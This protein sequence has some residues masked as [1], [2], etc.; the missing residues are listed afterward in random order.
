MSPPLWEPYHGRADWV[1]REEIL[2]GTRNSVD[3]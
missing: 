3:K 2:S 1:K